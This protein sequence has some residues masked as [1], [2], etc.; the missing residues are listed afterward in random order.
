MEYIKGNNPSGFYEFNN[1]DRYSTQ[2][3][4]EHHFGKCSHFTFKNSL[5]R[6]QRGITSPGYGFTGTQNGTFTEATYAYHGDKAEWVSGINLLTDHFKE[7]Q[8]TATSCETISTDDWNIYSK[9]A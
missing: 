1:T 9:Y 5:N 3:S 6:F 7:T 2:L 8:L 4:I